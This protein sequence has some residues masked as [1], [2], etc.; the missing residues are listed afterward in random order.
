LLVAAAVVMLLPPPAEAAEKI[1]ALHLRAQ[2]AGLA[3][4][5]I[6]RLLA[7]A[8]AQGEERAETLSRLLPLLS[9]AQQAGLPLDPLLDKLEQGFAKRVDVE[10]LAAA[11]RQKQTDLAF[12]RRLLARFHDADAP[13]VGAQAALILAGS[14]ELGLTPEAAAA[15]TA[16]LP[17]TSP[18]LM[19]AVALETKALCGQLEFRAELIDPILQAAVERQSLGPEWRRL[20]NLVALARQRGH[21][22]DAIAATATDV[23]QRRGAPRDVLSAL[24]FT[25]R[26][27]R[28]PP[29]EDAAAPEGTSR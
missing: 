6:G 18:A 4:A 22:D 3:S 14:L 29:I 10:R 9:E 16:A 20:A 8:Y 1:A 26:S 23:L 28:R 2:H 27:L 21:S 7:I 5:A 19:V 11:L 25:G 24:G 17:D 13:A 15:F 12:S